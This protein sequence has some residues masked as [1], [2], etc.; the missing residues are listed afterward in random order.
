MR[1]ILKHKLLIGC[2]AAVVTLS[3]TLTPIIANAATTNV[4]SSVTRIGGVDQYAT[5]ALI[6]QKGWIGISENV[7]LSAG[8]NYSLVD[9]L[10]AGP[11]AAKLKAPILLTDGGQGLNSF[12][13]AGLQRLKP[14]K[15][16]IT[17]GTAVIKSSVIDEIKAMGITPIE[18]GGYDQYETSVNIAK[19]MIN[20]GVPVSKVVLAAGWVTPA[21]ALSI[22][23]IAATQ[24]MPILA[25]TRDVLPPSVKSFL[26]SLANVTDSYVIGGTAVVGAGV[27][28][29]LPGIPHRYAGLTKY[30]TNI[31]VLKGFQ[32]FL[33]NEKTY[34]ANGET[35]VD[36]LAGVPMAAQTSSAILLTDKTL[37]TTSRDYAFLNLPSELVA[38][39]GQAVVFQNVLEQ[40]TSD[41]TLPQTE[42]NPSTGGGGGG[43]GGTP[44]SK[45]INVQ[46]IKVLM[47][48]AFSSGN[49]SNGSTLDLSDAPDTI[50]LTGFSITVNQS[51]DLQFDSFDSTI[52]LTGGEATQVN[53]DDLIS[54]THGGDGISLKTLRAFYGNSIPIQGELIKNASVVG[55]LSLTLKL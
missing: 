15:V 38:L 31:K 40:I 1:N 24:G 55:N 18:L 10:A 16:Y 52:S 50:Q 37:P 21:D 6:A 5:A 41:Q 46:N 19:E 3:S 20:Q 42:P 51:C 8:M 27:Q 9:A 23:P 33:K 35:L 13:K 14:K 48:P 26:A 43:G 28:A 54:G 11:L 32:E 34:V 39:G 53:L 47:V 36:A 12:A 25:T 45:T 2:M 4:S 29:Q 30:D 49:V 44:I 22:A 17:S 7:V